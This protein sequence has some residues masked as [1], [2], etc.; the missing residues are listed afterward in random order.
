MEERAS[1]AWVHSRIW[2][3]PPPP[4]LYGII[5]LQPKTLK[6]FEFKGLIGKIFRNKDFNPKPFALPQSRQKLAQ[7]F[8]SGMTPVHRLNRAVA[9][10]CP[11][12]RGK[13]PSPHARYRGFV[14][15]NEKGWGVTPH[16]LV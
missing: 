16:P 9:G 14:R 10:L 8:G 11:P 1:P 2:G 4:G 6:I 3:E 7:D 13:A 5:G 15:L 12:G